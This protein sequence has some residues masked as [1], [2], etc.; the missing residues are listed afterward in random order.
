MRTIIIMKDSRS[1]PRRSAA[2]FTLVDLSL[3]MS[4]AFVSRK[5][6]TSPPMMT[7]D[8]YPETKSLNISRGF[9]FAAFSRA[10]SGS[11][12]KISTSF[13]RSLA[14]LATAG[15]NSA[16]DSRLKLKKGGM[17]PDAITVT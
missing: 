7:V 13:A 8:A 16:S 1:V 17:P 11:A 6:R 4:P 12:P 5:C 15:I 14:S 3:K 2:A 9:L 10:L